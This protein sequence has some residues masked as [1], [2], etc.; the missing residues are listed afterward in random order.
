MKWC[1]GCTY[2]SDSNGSFWISLCKPC[3]VRLTEKGLDFRMWELNTPCPV[4]GDGISLVTTETILVL[5][6]RSGAVWQPMAFCH[7]SPCL[8]AMCVCV[9]VWICMCGY[10]GIGGRHS[11]MFSKVNQPQTFNIHISQSVTIYGRDGSLCSQETLNLPLYSHQV[12][13]RSALG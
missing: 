13:L 4:L 3:L 11:A 10:F 5:L 8:P 6:A 9:C 12:W 1:L 7:L 2:E